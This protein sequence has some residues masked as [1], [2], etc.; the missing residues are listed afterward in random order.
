M[1][2]MFDPRQHLPLRGTIALQFI[3]DDH[4]WDIL[5]AFEE[6]AEELLSGDLI[7]P[8]LHQ[9]IE[10]VP[11]PVDGAP[12]IVPFTVDR[13]EHFVQVPCVAQSGAPAPKLVGVWL[14][15]F[16]TPLSGGLIGDGDATHKEQLFDI[17]VTEAEP[18]VQPDAVADDLAREAV[19][20]VAI[21][22]WCVHATSMSHLIGLNK[23]TKPCPGLHRTGILH[24]WERGPARTLVP[25]GL[26]GRRSQAL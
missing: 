12:Q 20:L 11:I 17:P 25:A 19:V 16:P 3:G 21:G 7:A 6:L 14:A 23:V 4:A 1:L 2:S 15:K 9:D 10:H 24:P 8:S 26:R 13:E 18:V 22:D 5:A